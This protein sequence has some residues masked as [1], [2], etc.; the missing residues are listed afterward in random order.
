MNY[1]RRQRKPSFL[2]LGGGVYG[3]S[4]KIKGKLIKAKSLPGYRL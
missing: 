3:A 2:A 1:D 4:N